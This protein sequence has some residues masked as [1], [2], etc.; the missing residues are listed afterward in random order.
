MT[1]EVLVFENDRTRVFRIPAGDGAQ[2]LIRKE[3]YGP[4]ASRR[5]RHERAILSRLA[6]VPGVPRLIE[7]PADAHAIV[8]A[9]AGGESL[10]APSFAGPRDPGELI[11]LAVALA[12][13]IAALHRRGV[14]HKD[15]NPANIVVAGSPPRPTLID[16]DLATTFAT[17]RPAFTHHTEIAG[18]LAYLAPE[19]TGRTGWPVDQRADLY[20]FGATLYELA[21]GSPP[22][23]DG[24]PLQLT[25]DHL[26]RV[27]VPVS[28]VNPRMPAVLSEIIAHLLEKEPD[29]RYQSAEGVLHDLCRL[30]DELARGAEATF[31]TGERDFPWRLTAP[32]RLVGRETEIATIRTALADAVAGRCRVLLVSGAAGVGKTA[33]IDELRPLV[34]AGGGWFGSGKFDQYRQDPGSDAV[35]QAFRGIGRMLLAEP[36][37]RL[38]AVRSRVRTAA[39][40]DAGLIAALLPEFGQLLGVAA[41]ADADDPLRAQARLQ[42]GALAMLHALASDDRPLVIVVDDLQWGGAGPV[43]FLDAVAADESLRG[44]LVVGA[45]REAEVDLVHPLT[46]LLARWDERPSAPH[47]RLANLPVAEQGVL[48][49]EMLRAPVARAQELA[50]A[51]RAHTGGNPFDTVEFVN[52]L[53]RDGALSPSADGWAWDPAAVRRHIGLG[54]VVALLAARVAALPRSTR[55]I[56]DVMACLG[57]DVDLRLLRTAAI[58][59][60]PAGDAADVEDLLGPALEDGLLVMEEGADPSVRFRHDRVQQATYR[61]LDEAE[62][63]ALRLAVGRRLSAMPAY[64]GMAAEQ[65]LPVVAALTDDVEAAVVVQLLREAATHARQLANYPVAERFLVAAIELFDRVLAVRGTDAAARALRNELDIDRHAALVGLGRFDEADAVWIRLDRECSDRLRRADAASIQ[66][67]SLTARGRPP[68][69]V[70]LGLTVLADLGHPV[71]PDEVLPGEIARGVDEL[72]AWVAGTDVESDVRRAGDPDPLADAVAQIINRLI[73]AAFFSGSPVMPWLVTSA[74]QMWARRGP[75]AA[76]VGPVAHAAFVTIA[77]RRDYRTGYAAVRRVLSVSEELGYEPESSEARFLYA[78]SASPWFEPLEEGIRHA[79]RAHEGLVRGG[80]LYVAGFTFFAST[81]TFECAPAVEDILAEAERGLAFCARTGNQHVAAALVAYRQAGRALR[82]ETGRPGELSDAEFNEEAHLASL[83]A[84]PTSVGNY[85]AMRALVAVIFGDQAAVAR[86]AATAYALMPTFDATHLTA[87]VHLLQALSLAGQAAAAPEADRAALLAEFDRY[88]DWIADRAAEAP[89]NFAHMRAL[90]DAERARVTAGFEAVVRAYDVAQREVDARQRPWLR[91]VV[92]E[93]RGRFHLHEGVEHTARQALREARRHY[94]QWGA[95]GKVAE[96]DREFPFLRAEGG[97]AAG[98]RRTA[99]ARRSSSISSEMIDALAV[100]RA[101]QALSSQTSLAGLQHQVGEVLCALTG[102]TSVH[103]LMWDPE[104]AGWFLPPSDRTG[105]AALLVDRAAADGLLPLSVFRYAER[106]REP[107]LVEDAIRDDRFAGDPYLR[108]L[109][110]CALMAVPIL[111]RGEPSA[112]LILENRNSRGA[113]GANRLETVQLI[114]GQL[115]VS[116]DNALL[117]AA[118]ERKVADRT[119][120]LKA[121]NDQLEVLAV[122]D[123][124]TGLPN[125]RALTEMLELQWRLRATQPIAIAMIDIDHFKLYNDRYGHQSGDECLRKVATAI[126]GSLRSTDLVARYGGEEF[127]VVLPGADEV[128]AAWVTERVRAAVAGLAEPHEPAAH[129]IVTVSIGVA[130]GVPGPATSADQLIKAA[131]T[132]LYEAKRGGRNRVVLAAPPA[133]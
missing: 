85:H 13:I 63:Q 98:S 46:A 38:E 110:E 128:A 73:P 45:Y 60:D 81:T 20:A 59:A 6:D 48:L 58:P 120:A 130:V 132:E 108:P 133:G 96:L 106:T 125:R 79:Y 76:L 30:R 47:L 121:A 23:G 37:S 86:S 33:L 39:G 26:I 72:E 65:Y 87:L 68:E 36:E 50:E 31:A 3:P 101:S 24:D 44:V 74:A 52:A 17:E 25:Y 113:F 126:S 88:R 41:A 112:M 61:L 119:E 49:A 75:S 40:A 77:M 131:D 42:Q 12:E 1:D 103:L 34:T 127:A 53:R 100:V 54:D 14:V 56:L 27:P 116:V 35:L 22:F 19:Q 28:Q 43:G 4:A 91:A 18:T 29:R 90:L 105:G 64:R 66:L 62:M 114:A 16:Y 111:S 95:A 117:Y 97:P 55:D 10:A 11:T 51:I 99:D 32:A 15:I 129:G 123:P 70:A 89:A 104:E 2:A 124:L 21:T 107:L 5:C 7:G 93:R 92:A 115:S 118:L 109:A 83:V 94:E 78:L 84:N 69:A 67:A 122:T 82:G 57:G 80:N 71:P 102:A 8:L 9:D